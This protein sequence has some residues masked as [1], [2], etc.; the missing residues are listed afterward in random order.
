MLMRFTVSKNKGSYDHLSRRSIV[1]PRHFTPGNL[2]KDEN[3]IKPWPLTKFTVLKAS[4]PSQRQHCATKN[5]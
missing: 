2:S 3:I 1:Q 5:H 4:A